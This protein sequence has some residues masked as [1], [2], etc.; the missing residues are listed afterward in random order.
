[1]QFVK[2]TWSDSFRIQDPN[3][4]LNVG[5]SS[6][7]DIDDV[8]NNWVKY[9]DDPAY[10]HNKTVKQMSRGARRGVNIT[11]DETAKN[12]LTNY[13]IQQQATVNNIQNIIDDDIMAVRD[14]SDLPVLQ[15]QKPIV[16]F[17]GLVHRPRFNYGGYYN[18]YS[19][20]NYIQTPYSSVSAFNSPITSED[21]SDKEASYG[22][23]SLR[24]ATFRQGAASGASWGSGIGGLV[25]GIGASILGTS[26]AGSAAGAAGGAAA[27]AG[28][29]V[30][31]GAGAGAAGGAAAGAAAGAASTAWIPIIGP[32][33]ALV[34][35]GIGAGIGYGV[36]KKKGN[37]LAAKQ[38]HDNKVQIA[39]NK[40]LH[41]QTSMGNAI[42]L[43][44]KDVA[45]IRSMTPNYNSVGFYSK[46]G[47]LLGTARRRF[48]MGGILEPTSSDTVLAHGRT[49]EEMDP[50]TGQTG[51]AYKGAEIENNEVVQETPQGDKVFSDSIISPRTGLTY[52][53][54][55]EKISKAKGVLEKIKTQ[56]MTNLDSIIEQVNKGRLSGA[57]LGTLLRNG[58]KKATHINKLTGEIFEKDLAL[59]KLFN[60][61]ETVAT[62]LGLRDND[63]MRYG[64]CLRRRYFDGGWIAPV[65]SFG[66]NALTSGL[67]YWATDS[68][69]KYSQEVL[70]GLSKL[71]V[72]RE[73]YDEPIL[74]NPEYDITPELGE[75][76][77]EAAYAKKF[78]AD[79]IVNPQQRR[80]LMRKV[81]IEATQQV[82]K[83]KGIKKAEEKKVV[84]ANI[85]EIGAVRRSNRQKDYQYLVNKY[86]KDSQIA[87][88]KLQIKANQTQ[89]TQQLL[90]DLGQSATQAASMYVAS[91]QW[92]PGVTNDMNGL[93]GKTKSTSDKV[94]TNLFQPTLF[95][96]PAR[97]TGLI[98]A[99]D[100][101]KYSI[102]N[103]TLMRMMLY[104]G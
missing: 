71:D 2:G 14:V 59:N 53:K 77:R 90:R 58:E 30:A 46:Y 26:L 93:K 94:V 20:G 69:N 79:N 100:F 68:Y 98:T 40:E 44:D 31:A 21:I 9:A 22:I 70:E 39:Q 45:K 24:K 32:L 54:N 87:Q 29:G 92:A 17:G 27:G 10:D 7:G 61:Q 38:L 82:N 43:I 83:L 34:A 35:A 48:D 65:A 16:R 80:N 3:T 81:G 60:E 84:D 25:G 13:M 36:N 12:T 85:K 99:P 52:A 1:M 56:E 104:N 88:Q 4:G 41:R 97:Y 37:T 95:N 96:Q 49:H 86:N 11:L 28:A 63:M 23:E 50:I 101:S 76:N 74:L 72:P 55:A 47:G 102:M 6:P 18:N 15:E 66:A 78:I 103:P 8:V 89:A 67:Q 57:K 5:F 62:S 91:K 64:G 51:I 19:G 73:A 42:N 75:V 33:V